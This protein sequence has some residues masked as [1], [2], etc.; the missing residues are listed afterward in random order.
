MQDERR[1]EQDA[2]EVEGHIRPKAAPQSEDPGKVIAR[3]EDPGKLIARSE[4]EDLEVEAHRWPR[5]P[6]P[7]EDPSA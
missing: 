1:T 6:A 3:S 2:D 4:D 5:T 7:P